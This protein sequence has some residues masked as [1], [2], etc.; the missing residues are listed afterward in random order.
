MTA[1]ETPGTAALGLALFPFLFAGFAASWLLGA[2][3]LST[4]WA[5]HVEPLGVPAIGFWHAFG[6]IAIARLIRGYRDVS[7]AEK[8]E[9]E[10]RLA[11]ENLTI[12]LAEQAKSA[13]YVLA[14]VAFAWLAWKV[15]R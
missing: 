5:W 6:L 13:A 9:A 2:W 7:S 11:A 12:A 8:R 4:V 15:G 3:A 1:K 10:G 14:S